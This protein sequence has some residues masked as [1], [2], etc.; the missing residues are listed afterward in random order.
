MV[1]ELRIS[2]ATSAFPAVV[3]MVA[4]P[5]LAQDLLTEPAGPFLVL[6]IKFRERAPRVAGVSEG[7]RGGANGKDRLAGTQ[8]V[9]KILHLIVRQFAKPQLH[10]QHIGA[11]ERVQARH[12]RLVVR[13]NRAVPRIDREKDCA[14]EPLPHCEDLGEHRHGLF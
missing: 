13:I 14:L 10:D 6:P 9:H 8:V 12:V 7:V 1:L 4:D 2:D 11:L 5:G 3:A